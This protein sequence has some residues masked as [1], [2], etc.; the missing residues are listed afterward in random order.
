MRIL[1]MGKFAKINLFEKKF[2]KI[3]SSISQ[4]AKCV[5][6]QTC[7]TKFTQKIISLKVGVNLG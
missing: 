6:N 7:K 1:W 5:E 2:K 4:N 3:K